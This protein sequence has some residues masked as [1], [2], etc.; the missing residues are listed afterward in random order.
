MQDTYDYVGFLV[1]DCYA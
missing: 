1:V